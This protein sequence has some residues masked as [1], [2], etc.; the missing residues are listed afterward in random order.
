MD[1]FKEQRNIELQN[2]IEE[3][4]KRW[5]AVKAKRDELEAEIGELQAQIMF[6]DALARDKD[7][8]YNEMVTKKE[9]LLEEHRKHIEENKELADTLNIE[10]SILENLKN[11]TIDE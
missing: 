5:D 11:K 10:I 9:R 3:R 7:Q 6:R 4:E 1:R 8:A 2:M